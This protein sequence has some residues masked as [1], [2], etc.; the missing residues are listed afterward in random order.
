MKKKVLVSLVTSEVNRDEYV[1]GIMPTKGTKRSE[2]WDI[3]LPCD[4]F[5]P[6]KADS[7]PLAWPMNVAFKMPRGIYA[8]LYPRSSTSI[9]HNITIDIG[10]IDNDYNGTIHCVIRNFNKQHTILEKGMRI[11]QIV[12]NKPVN[13]VQGK[14]SMGDRGGLGST[15]I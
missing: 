3:Y 13:L 7:L 12:F 15:G 11:A 5:V 14:F 1:F 9:K 10:V 4:I 2:G 8:V 6:G